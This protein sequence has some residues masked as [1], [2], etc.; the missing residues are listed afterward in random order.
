[1][2]AR[3]LYRIVMSGV[4]LVMFLVPVAMLLWPGYVESTTEEMSVLPAY[5]KFRCALCHTSADPAQG[6]AGLNAFG[7]DFDENGRVWDVTLAML[8][9]DN[10]KCLNGFELG[11]SDGDGF[12]DHA[13]EHVE[14]SNP[15]DPADCSIALTIQTWGKIK[16]VFRGEMR[17]YF[18][19]W[20]DVELNGGQW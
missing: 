13:G 17:N 3:R 6:D 4:A 10:D 1:M 9:S 12:F 18:G 16:E 2:S 15:G 8:N 20:D 7:V 14:H 5:S 19:D 11:D